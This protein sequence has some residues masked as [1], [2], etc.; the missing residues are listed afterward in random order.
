MQAKMA[1]L[2]REYMEFVLWITLCIY[3]FLM[4]F[5]NL[6]NMD[7]KRN[8]CM[9][10]KTFEIL[11]KI[12][13]WKISQKREKLFFHCGGAFLEVDAHQFFRKRILNCPCLSFCILNVC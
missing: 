13:N 9:H 11:L 4:T 5:P 12:Y 7:T 6:L 1:E 2:V 8:T 3:Y 10:L